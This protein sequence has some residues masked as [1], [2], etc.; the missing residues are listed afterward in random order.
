MFGETYVSELQPTVGLLYTPRT[1]VLNLCS[2]TSTVVVLLFA[3]EHR[4]I[5]A[6][7]SKD[8]TFFKELCPLSKEH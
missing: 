1:G 6:R 4:L 3:S 7:T 5:S 8:Q 2:S